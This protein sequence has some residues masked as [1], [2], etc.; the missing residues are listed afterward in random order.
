MMGGGKQGWGFLDISM[1]L[2][3][4]GLVVLG[5]RCVF[6]LSFHVTQVF[7]ESFDFG[8]GGG[9]DFGLHNRRKPV[10]PA[11]INGAG[12]AAVDAASGALGRREKLGWEE[13]TKNSAKVISFIGVSLSSLSFSFSFSVSNPN[14]WLDLAG[15][16]VP[17]PFAPLSANSRL[18]DGLA[19]RYIEISQNNPLWNDIRRTRRSDPHGRRE[20]RLDRHEQ[21][22]SCYCARFRRAC[23]CCYL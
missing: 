17:I 8:L 11:A 10:M 9:S 14:S 22:A 4:G 15:H 1:R 5:W 12:A 18:T 21:G 7:I 19:R 3:V 23:L 16:E 13:I 2:R 20:R 6:I